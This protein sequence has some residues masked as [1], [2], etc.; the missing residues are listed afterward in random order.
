M[1]IKFF[2][3]EASDLQLN[4]WLT[5]DFPDIAGEAYFVGSILQIL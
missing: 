3:V 5:C 2:E 1:H 4:Y